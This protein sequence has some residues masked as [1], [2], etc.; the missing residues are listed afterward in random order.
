M[1]IEHAESPHEVFFY[2]LINELQAVRSGKWKLQL[3]A[4]KGRNQK[5]GKRGKSPF[6]LY[7]LETDLA[8]QRNVLAE[9]PEVV[10]RLLGLAEDFKQELSANSRPAGYV[11]QPKPLT[12]K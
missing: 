6:A 8:E 12:M 1:L 2:H 11:K 9:H 7:D 4:P 3:V 5:K 10:Q